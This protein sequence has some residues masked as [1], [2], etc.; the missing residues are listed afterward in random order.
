MSLSAL[1][2]T[3]VPITIE[4][5]LLPFAE[6]F[7]SR[8]WRIDALTR[9]A[10][11]YP[12]ILGAFDTLYDI[13]W[14]R[15][16]LAISDHFDTWAR[17]RRIVIEGDYDVVHVH[18]PIAAFV[19]RFALRSIPKAERPVIIYTAH[20]FHFYEGQS[21]VGHMVFRTME[22]MAAPWTD[23]LVT[24]NR[25]DYKAARGFR[26]IDPER[27][28]WIP[29]IGVDVDRFSPAEVSAEQADAIRR[30]LDVPSDAFMLTMIAEF[31]PVKRHVHLLEA[32]SYVRD[33]RVIVTFVGQGD[34]E[35][36]IRRKVTELGLD[37][38]VRWAGFRHDIPAVLAAS[39]ALTLVSAREGLPRSVL[40]AMA[41]GKPI[42]GT[43]TR[44]ITDAVGDEAGWLVSKDDAHELA[45]AI[46][47]AAANPAD[48]DQRGAAA[49]IRAREHYSVSEVL[50]D[51]EAL[52][53]EA[54]ALKAALPQDS[55]DHK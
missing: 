27:V 32:L 45:D 11:R 12:S 51:Y 21:F 23:F 41:M 14:S 29:G 25:E 48:V 26:H 44:G 36:E 35:E 55:G 8:G 40:E 33:P 3:T 19:T 5:F 52:Y 49:R 17:V 42:I 1:F 9:E 31:S 50:G 34:L 4:A 24:I 18:T 2:V 7:H 53:E 16:P 28:R 20:G 43:R 30:E 54:R 37:D 10:T 47:A 15:N 46:E 22:R 38:R 6:R 13:T 39:N